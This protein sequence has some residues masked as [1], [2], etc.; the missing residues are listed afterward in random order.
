[1]ASVDVADDIFRIFDDEVATLHERLGNK[2][3]IFLPGGSRQNTL[4]STTGIWMF[5]IGVPFLALVGFLFLSVR[6]YFRHTPA[7]LI[8]SYWAW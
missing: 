8:K 2:L 5:A 3:D 1:M 7:P 4:F 6:T